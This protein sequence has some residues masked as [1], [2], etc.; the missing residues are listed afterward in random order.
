MPQLQARHKE[1]LQAREKRQRKRKAREM[2]GDAVESSSDSCGSDDDDPVP[3]FTLAALEHIELT[4]QAFGVAAGSTQIKE[5][6]RCA[7]V[8][9]YKKAIGAAEEEDEPQ[10]LP[11]PPASAASTNENKADAAQAVVPETEQSKKKSNLPAIRQYVPDRSCGEGQTCQINWISGARGEHWIARY[12]FDVPSDVIKPKRDMTQCSRTKYL[13]KEPSEHVAFQSVLGWIWREHNL[14]TSEEEPPHVKEML[15]ECALC[16]KDPQS[17][18]AM[19]GLKQ[20][21]VDAEA[22]GAPC[23]K[24]VGGFP[25]VGSVRFLLTNKRFYIN[26]G[27]DQDSQT[28]ITVPTPQSTSNNR[29]RSA[30]GVFFSK[31]PRKVKQWHPV[32]AVSVAYSLMPMMLALGHDRLRLRNVLRTCSIIFFQRSVAVTRQ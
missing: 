15:R 10:P 14:C 29:L 24:P 27:L 5:K 13:N 2:D 6:K 4:G 18:K 20:K 28:N 9:K 11:P 23:P 26:F 1:M 8:S 30:L 19:E 16:K 3:E 22:Q 12:S 25:C 31:A 7:M 17:C 32:A 21:K